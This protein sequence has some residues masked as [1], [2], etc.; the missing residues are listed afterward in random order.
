MNSKKRNKKSFLLFLG[1]LVVFLVACGEPLGLHDVTNLTLP[2]ELPQANSTGDQGESTTSTSNINTKK[3]EPACV[4]EFMRDLDGSNLNQKVYKN[5]DGQLFIRTPEQTICELIPDTLK[6][7]IITPY[8]IGHY[9]DQHSNDPCLFGNDEHLHSGKDGQD[10]CEKL[11]TSSSS[12]ISETSNEVTQV[13]SYA[14][15]TEPNIYFMPHN[16]YRI[17]P[18]HYEVEIHSQKRICNTFPATDRPLFISS[19]HTNGVSSNNGKSQIFSSEDPCQ[20][21]RL[22]SSPCSDAGCRSNS[23]CYQSNPPPGNQDNPPDCRS[24]SPCHRSAHPDDQPDPDCH[25]D[26]HCH[27]SEDSNDDDKTDQKTLPPSDDEKSELTKSED[28]KEEEKV[29]ESFRYKDGYKDWE[30][31]VHSGRWLAQYTPYRKKV[32]ILVI[33]SPF[34]QEKDTIKFS[35]ALEKLMNDFQ[36]HSVDWQ[37]ATTSAYYYDERSVPYRIYPVNYT[38]DKRGVT[39]YIFAPDLIQ[40]QVNYNEG[41][42]SDP[43]NSNRNGNGRTFENIAPWIKESFNHLPTCNRC[44]NRPLFAFEY[45]LRQTQ[46]PPKGHTYKFFR[47][48]AELVVLFLSRTNDGYHNFT[49]PDENYRGFPIDIQNR[50]N[51]LIKH[52][53]QQ[54]HNRTHK[55]WD[56]GWREKKISVINV[57]SPYAPLNETQQ[58]FNQQLLQKRRTIELAYNDP[59]NPSSAF[60]L[61]KKPVHN[62]PDNPSS[63]ITLVEEE[64]CNDEVK[65][66]RPAT[67]LREL[68]SQQLSTG[69]LLKNEEGKYHYS[70]VKNY[71]VHTKT[72]ANLNI[73]SNEYDLSILST[74]YDE[75]Q[76]QILPLH[77]TFKDGTKKRHKG[78][79]VFKTDRTIVLSTNLDYLAIEDSVQVKR[80]IVTTR[81]TTG[82]E[83]QTSTLNADSFTL[84]TIGPDHPEYIQERTT[85]YTRITFKPMQTTDIPY[86]DLYYEIQYQKY[87]E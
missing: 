77:Q 31:V 9:A 59:D 42:K 57:V 64:P 70:T 22:I 16:I 75:Q 49:N 61:V 43:F 79:W 19:S 28:P 67:A 26:S 62:D 71:T 30:D 76:D 13:R 82:T 21:A 55:N 29:T 85:P 11:G 24:D 23:P 56:S 74:H 78:R 34:Y 38:F 18:S 46:K 50:M 40:A 54:K 20:T 72:S 47:D 17:G 32:D 51:A 8:P 39:Q 15:V 86:G 48:D 66:I 35:N 73:C 83:E 2:P 44:A 58:E 41:H 33:L 14:S 10:C 63:A 53:H 87:Q 68:T 52:R 37:L 25:S 3:T 5:C 45:I 6:L 65:R 12:Q 80:T 60:T 4:P 36:S 84:E 69:V 7:T 1:F 81:K 27:H